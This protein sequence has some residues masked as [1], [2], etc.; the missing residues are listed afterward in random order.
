MKTT[1][2]NEM[3]YYIIG[4]ALVALGAFVHQCLVPLSGLIIL[5]VGTI[6]WAYGLYDAIKRARGPSRECRKPWIDRAEEWSGCR[7]K[8]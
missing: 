1:I 4:A 6:V 8:K 3:F 5:S 2:V 7:R